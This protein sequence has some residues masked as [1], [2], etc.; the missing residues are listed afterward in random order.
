VQRVAFFDRFV[1]VEHH[2]PIQLHHLLQ[3]KLEIPDVV[4]HACQT[5]VNLSVLDVHLFLQLL[6]GL[7]LFLVPPGRHEVQVH[8]VATASLPLEDA[9]AFFEA[10]VLI[11]VG[12]VSASVA[13]KPLEKDDVVLE[14]ALGHFVEAGRLADLQLLERVFHQ[15]EVPEIVLG[16]FGTEIQ[17][18]QRQAAGVDGVQQLRKA[19]AIRQGLYGHVL[20]LYYAV[21]PRQKFSF[22]QIHV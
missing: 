9:H 11:E 18:H 12:L 14:H 21:E 7:P 16:V 17:T 13:V 3:L 1:Y 20:G 5:V 2:L 6:A 19:H 10:E 22:A 4:V 15:S 8:L